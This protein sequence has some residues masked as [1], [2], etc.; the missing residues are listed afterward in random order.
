[1]YHNELIRVSGV[2]VIYIGQ[3][4]IGGPNPWLI[5]GTIHT[6]GNSVINSLTV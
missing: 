1:M 3:G 4:Y 2:Q 5:Q 6:Q